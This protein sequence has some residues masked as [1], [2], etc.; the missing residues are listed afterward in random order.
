MGEG[1]R[2]DKKG[3]TFNNLCIVMCEPAKERAGG[4]QKKRRGERD[5][6]SDCVCVRETFL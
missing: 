1:G 2:R 3:E 5:L 6:E 4:R